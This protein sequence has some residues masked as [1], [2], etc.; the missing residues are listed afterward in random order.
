MNRIFILG[1]VA[2]LLLALRIS[3]E[4]PTHLYLCRSP[5]LAFNFWEALLNLQH[6]GITVT[7]KITQEVCDGMRAGS[8]PQCIRAEGEDFKPVASGWGGTMAMTDGKT[9]IWFHNPDTAGWIHPDY[10]VSYVNAK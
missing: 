2:I 1:F 10:Y 8:E 5:L 6:Q 3:A 7:P 9:R 4:K